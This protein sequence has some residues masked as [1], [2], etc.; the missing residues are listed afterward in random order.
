MRTSQ[1]QKRSTP[2]QPLG[3]LVSLIV[4]PAIIVSTVAYIVSAR[5]YAGHYSY[6]IDAS[7]NAD[8]RQQIIKIT[9]ARGEHIALDLQLGYINQWATETGIQLTLDGL[10]TPLQIVGP[11]ERDWGNTYIVFSSDSKML[12]LW[13]SVTLPPSTGGP[14]QRQLSG[15]ITGTIITPGPF[16][17]SSQNLNLPIQFLLIS[18][19]SFFWSGSRIIFYLMTGIHALLLVGLLI[20]FARPRLQAWRSKHNAPH[21][22][23]ASE[24]SGCASFYIMLFLGLV[25]GTVFY[26]SIG[27]PAQIDKA[28]F[29][30]VIASIWLLLAL[31]MLVLLITGDKIVAWARS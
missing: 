27:P 26:I 30:D 15:K 21:V 14:Q 20:F 16:G 18:Q 4:I 8:S 7:K 11:K 28:G 1:A 22:K 23:A 24:K 19:Q 5:N 17:E 12:E 2:S 3:R 25:L 31:A 9:A 29:T 13:S 10:S 6:T